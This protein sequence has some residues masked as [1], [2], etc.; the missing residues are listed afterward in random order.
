[1]QARQ[2]LLANNK[3]LFRFPTKFHR[4]PW[5]NHTCGTDLS[6]QLVF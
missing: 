3:A 6:E 2:L 5:K 1:M 4:R